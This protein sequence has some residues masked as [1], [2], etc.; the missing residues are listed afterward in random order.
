MTELIAIAMLSRGYTAEDCPDA[1]RR[2]HP[3][4]P[5]GYIDRSDWGEK[6]SKTHEQIR[7]PKCGFYAVW[8][9]KA[10]P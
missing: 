4:P 9:R 1:G 3:I 2:D 6:K 10:K 7:C 8:T 5:S